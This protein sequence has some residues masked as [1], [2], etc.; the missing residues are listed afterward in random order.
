M[1][2]RWAEEF[3]EWEAGAVANTVH[4]CSVCDGELGYVGELDKAWAIIH[5]KDGAVTP[6]LVGPS[7]SLWERRP[8]TWTGR[9]HVPVPGVVLGGVRATFTPV[10]GRWILGVARCAG[11]RV[12]L[13]GIVGEEEI[14]MAVLSPEPVLAFVGRP[15]EIGTVNLDHFDWLRGKAT[16]RSTMSPPPRSTRSRTSTS[17]PSPPPAPAARPS[18]PQVEQFFARVRAAL[19][20]ASHSRKASPAAIA[21]IPQV[22]DA[23]EQWAREGRGP[24][25]GRKV[26]VHAELAAALPDFRM[27]VDGV[28]AALEALEQVC[29]DFVTLSARTWHI[30]MDPVFGG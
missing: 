3:K 11:G 9:G 10:W 8:R 29:G 24:F 14:G 30:H 15:L 28:G 23:L 2:A 22:I 25:K 16:A 13:L 26:K 17:Q 7:E 6:L 5:I 27:S 12:V 18:A 20:R 19:P 21:E 4:R 1:V